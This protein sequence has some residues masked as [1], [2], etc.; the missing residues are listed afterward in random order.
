MGKTRSAKWDDGEGPV[1]FTA[2]R[3]ELL[4]S[5][6]RRLNDKI[7]EVCRDQSGWAIC[8]V[9]PNRLLEFF[10]TLHLRSGYVM[11]AYQYA[12][13]GNGNAFVF[14]QK[15]AEEFPA[16]QA[17][18]DIDS[19]DSDPPRPPNAA[20]K[21]LSTIELDGT[22]WSYISASIFAREFAEFGAMWHG[23]DWGDHKIVDGRPTHVPNSRGKTSRSMTQI[24]DGN[25]WTWHVAEPEDWRP[26]VWLTLNEVKVEFF[27]YTAQGSCRIEQHADVFKGRNAEFHSETTIVASGPG[28]FV[29]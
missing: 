3:C 18:G 9:D 5:G 15:A 16:P 10:P 13:G 7:E 28:G 12:S 14:V 11:H 6:P 19:D 1:H 24:Q 27:S 2:R 22:A 17:Y 23:I 21:P 25:G 29:Y 8:P 4:R 20:A 26:T